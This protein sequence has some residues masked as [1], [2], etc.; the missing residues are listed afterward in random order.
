MVDF[1]NEQHDGTSSKH[2]K[3]QSK[4]QQKALE[5][6]TYKGSAS[7]NVYTGTAAFVSTYSSSKNTASS[8]ATSK[9]DSGTSSP[10]GTLTTMY[11]PANG[12]VSGESKPSNIYKGTAYVDPSPHTYRPGQSAAEL[13]SSVDHQTASPPQ[14][15]SPIP[16][17][18]GETIS[19]SFT[20]A[21]QAISGGNTNTL[22]SF[23]TSL[24]TKH[25]SSG[26]LNNTN[27]SN[28]SNNNNNNNTF[29][30][31]PALPRSSAS[32]PQHIEE[33]PFSYSTY[34][35]S[36][37]LSSNPPP[38]SSSSTPTAFSYIPPSAA[39]S[40]IQQSQP[41]SS[42]PINSRR[43]KRYDYSYKSQQYGRR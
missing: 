13:S 5:R 10:T 41:S 25:S 22:G 1:I 11:T 21:L 3:K 9:D 29:S 42:R 4:K 20:A 31:T 26:N 43:G 19:S 6:K 38:S 32:S 28:N 27:N 17:Q 2:K 18:T 33:S 35:S 12:D 14:P 24:G 40:D 37:T 8:T 36:P 30:Y 23:S 7:R 34:S 16:Q 39:S 15:A